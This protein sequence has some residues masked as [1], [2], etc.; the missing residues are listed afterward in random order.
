MN[1]YAYI[2]RLRTDWNLVRAQFRQLFKPRPGRYVFRVKASNHDGV[3]NEQGAAVR[4]R[5]IPPIYMIR[6]VQALALLAAALAVWGLVRKRINNIRRRNLQLE[7]KV[8][9]RTAE[10]R[11]AEA[12]A[13]EA[14]RAK[15]ESWPTEPRIRSTMNGIFGM[16][17][18]PSNKDLTPDQR[19]Y[20]E[21]V[22][23]SADSLM[24]IINDILDFSKIEAQ[25]IDLEKI[26]WRLRDTVHAAVAG[27]ALQAE[28]KNHELAYSI[29]GNVP[30][31]LIGDPG[32]FRQ[33]LTNLLSIRRQVHE[34]GRKSSPP[35]MW[36][37]E[38]TTPSGS[39]SGHG[40]RDRNPARKT[41]S[42]FSR[43]SPRRTPTTNR[44]FG[45]TGLGLTISAQLV[46]L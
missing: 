14:N 28:K 29:P 33:V 20:L 42:S 10:L 31:G 18:R 22:K 3:W 16:T 2:W 46:A 21:A 38:P 27:I 26:P 9:E 36:K 41:G 37:A 8:Q 13:R 44:V 23:S 5:V 35:S 19:E 39:A 11:K 32:R 6:W 45:G 7:E 17:E 15:S 25:K 12:E 34:H 4:V 1:P 43:P 40:H 30:A 24:T